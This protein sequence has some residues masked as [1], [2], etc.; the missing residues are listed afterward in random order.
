MR[1]EFAVPAD[2]DPV[3]RHPQA[4]PPGE[5]VGSH[6]ASCYGCG[7]RTPHGLHI[8]TIAG[9]GFTVY[10]DLRVEP[11]ME[12]GPG[13][14]HGGLLAT[15]IDEVLGSVPKLATGAAVTGH[16]KLD[17]L[18]PVPVGLTVRITAE[19]LGVK[20]RKIYS[21]AVVRPA[22]SDQELAI[23]HALFIVPRPR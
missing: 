7:P 5:P 6:N 17:Y 3:T 12:G 16:L 20:G 1:S 11:W 8:V 2:L 23:A 4:T 14:I 13:V 15:A 22:D 21:K 18:K 10:A 19:L 9:E